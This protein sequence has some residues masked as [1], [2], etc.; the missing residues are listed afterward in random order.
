MCMDLFPALP[1][2]DMDFKKG[3]TDQERRKIRKF[4]RTLFGIFD[5][6]A[7]MLHKSTVH[8]FYPERSTR[9]TSKI[10][11]NLIDYVDVQCTISSE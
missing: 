9:S 7:D 5:L 4:I 3:K 6:L 11:I 1:S 8:S 10:D 2:L